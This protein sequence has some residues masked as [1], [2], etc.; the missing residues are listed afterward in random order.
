[1]E[2]RNNN[3]QAEREL[4]EAYYKTN[5]VRNVLLIITIAMTVILLYGSLSIAYGKI[6]SDYLIDVRGMGTLATVSLENGS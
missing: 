1:M 5:K 4:S 6:R 2:F 3:R